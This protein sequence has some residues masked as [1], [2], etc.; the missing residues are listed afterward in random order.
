M[1]YSFT[2]HLLLFLSC[3]YGLVHAQND[4]NPDTNPSCGL[5]V[6][7]NP[8]TA[9]GLMTPYLLVAL[10]PTMGN[11]SMVTPVQ[12]AFV[13]AAILDLDTG[14]I[15]NYNPLVIDNGTAPAAPIT[16][17]T[18][19]QNNIVAIFIGTNANAFGTP[20]D[21]LTLISS[22]SS[23]DS[24]VQ[25]N[26]LQGTL[27]GLDMDLFGQFSMCNSVQFFAAADQLI[28]SGKLVVPPLGTAS[29]GYVC[30]STHSF[31]L[32]D[33][34][35]SDT[36][37]TNYLLTTDGRVAQYTAAN[38]KAFPSATL[39][40]N[41]S[42]ALLLSQMDAAI[43]CSPWLIQDLTDNGAVT[44][45]SS[46]ATDELQANYHQPFPQALVPALDPDVVEVVN[47]ANNRYNGQADLVKLNSYRS[48]VGQ[49]TVTHVS[50]A[51]I[52]FYC[53]GL[54]S[55][56]SHR[57]LSAQQY[58][59][60]A[61]SPDP[62]TGTNLFTFLASRFIETYQPGSEGFGCNTVL[63]ISCPVTCTYDE[64]GEI[65]LSAAVTPVD[66]L[67]I[68]STPTPSPTGANA[69]EAANKDQTSA[70]I[71]LAVTLAVVLALDLGMFIYWLV[72]V[73]KS[74][75]KQLHN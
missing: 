73:R 17:I 31:D 75:F 44:Y 26:C 54:L 5:I 28:V 21:T 36:V 40:D 7:P 48:G 30:P 42:D 47:V 56:G 27:L 50:Q 25:G 51:N 55:V 33:T 22:S 58:L 19:P 29:D 3:C 65:C 4:Y 9:Q 34:T 66:V 45:V 10:D 49:T 61:G 59:S 39:I 37:P 53:Q 8:L 32:V 38:I 64:T 69:P 52:T 68:Y 6:P 74:T 16:P 15:Y 43:G 18:L 20:N 12:Q 63:N 71:G 41:V 57:L 67:G 14:I 62:T 70:V 35:Q 46:F 13:N 1:A 60:A 11:C 72:R 2:L 24:L 23:V